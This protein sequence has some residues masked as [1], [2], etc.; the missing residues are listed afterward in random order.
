MK[1]PPHVPEDCGRCAER[2][3][4]RY[5]RFQ[6]SL[7]AVMATAEGRLV[8][9]QILDWTG[10][11]QRSLWDPSSRMHW[12]VGRRDLGK[13]LEDELLAAARPS[14]FT[15]RDERVKAAEMEEAEKRVDE[16]MLRK[17]R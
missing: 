14:Y 11:N 6:T 2:A 13:E 8:L 15:M 5:G 17:E 9:D 1:K 10:Q 3:K 7:Q 4:K 16:E 12:L